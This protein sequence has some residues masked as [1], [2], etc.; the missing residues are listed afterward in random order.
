MKR[1]T[2][3]SRKY[4]GEH[5]CLWP[6]GDA[7]GSPSSVRV[8]FFLSSLTHARIYLWAPS[9]AGTVPGAEASLVKQSMPWWGL[10]CSW[11]ICASN[12]I[13]V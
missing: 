1:K 5:G 13:N 2:L 12:A 4:L 10:H 7:H 3:E 11:K 6:V 9:M 8:Y